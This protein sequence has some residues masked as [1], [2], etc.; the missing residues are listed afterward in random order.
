M[1]RFYFD[2]YDGEAMALDEEGL[3]L[4]SVQAAQAEAAKS[5]AD[6]ARDA[7]HSTSAKPHDMTIDV[8][9]EAGP[10]M[11]VKLVFDLQTKRVKPS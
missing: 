10:I 8:R 4:Q 9:D 6:L 2:L 11:Q 7:I 5:L 3:E 1:P